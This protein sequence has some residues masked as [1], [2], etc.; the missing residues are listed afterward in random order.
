MFLLWIVI[1][2][3]L[4]ALQDTLDIAHAAAASIVRPVNG[5]EQSILAVVVQAVGETFQICRARYRP[6]ALLVDL[7]HLPED[8][9]L[10][11]RC[12]SRSILYIFTLYDVCIFCRGTTAFFT[13]APCIFCRGSNI[14]H[15]NFCRGIAVKYRHM[16]GNHLSLAGTPENQKTFLT[17]LLTKLDD[18]MLTLNI[19]LPHQLRVG[20]RKPLWAAQH[21]MY[22][23]QPQ[24]HSLF[25]G[26]E[27]ADAL[28]AERIQLS[29]VVH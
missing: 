2:I 17:Q 9:V 14:N 3:L 6:D 5:L 8:L 25:P 28:L 16:V 12:S 1:S 10:G 27:H 19:E 22:Q 21:V 11:W 23:K 7:D 24:V 26:I 18:G 20:Y 29:D 15:C 13:G 4:P